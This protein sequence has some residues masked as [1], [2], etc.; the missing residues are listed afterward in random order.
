MYLIMENTLV[1]RF[2]AMAVAAVASFVENPQSV[3][4]PNTSHPIK[5][6]D[7]KSATSHQKCSFPVCL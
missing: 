2:P 4:Q 1:P 7:N 3:R 5:Q 6:L